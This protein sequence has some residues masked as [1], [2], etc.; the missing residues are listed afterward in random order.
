MV[1]TDI[2]K[3]GASEVSVE[4]PEDYKELDL[5]QAAGQEPETG[6]PRKTRRSQAPAGLD[7]NTLMKKAMQSAE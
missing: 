5:L 6:T 1:V 3:I 2:K 4:I 7:F